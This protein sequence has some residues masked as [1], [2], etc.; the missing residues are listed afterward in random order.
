MQT[1]KR[2]KQTRHVVSALSLL[3]NIR[4]CPLRHRML[5]LSFHSKGQDQKEEQCISCCTTLPI[6]HD[7]IKVAIKVVT[8]VNVY[9]KVDLNRR[10]HRAVLANAPENFF[11]M[12]LPR[13]LVGQVSDCRV[14]LACQQFGVC[15]TRGE[16]WVC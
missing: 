15:M 8:N 4:S 2:R 9:A 3:H 1:A 11:Q 16:V 10:F 14:V 6:K 12:R 13:L 7:N 5:A